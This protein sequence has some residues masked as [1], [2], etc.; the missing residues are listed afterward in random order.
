MPSFSNLKVSAR[1]LSEA[2]HSSDVQKL[3]GIVTAL[4]KECQA[5]EEKLKRVE[6]TA[7]MARN[8]AQQAKNR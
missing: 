5:L 1:Q 4:A 3:A 7:Q 2:S 6:S 8:E